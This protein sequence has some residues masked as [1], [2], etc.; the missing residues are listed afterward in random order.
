MSLSLARVIWSSRILPHRFHD[1]GLYI[2]LIR[3][4]PSPSL[5]I[6]IQQVVRLRSFLYSP[7][8]SVNFRFIFDALSA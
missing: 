8:S 7:S 3:L 1:E 6:F 2:T 4:P 5:L